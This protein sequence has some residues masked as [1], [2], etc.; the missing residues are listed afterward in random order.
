[1]VTYKQITY[2]IENDLEFKYKTIY[3]DVIQTFFPMVS[4][5]RLKEIEGAAVEVPE[6]MICDKRLREFISK[7]KETKNS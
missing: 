6:C 3:S 2:F 5:P 1:M 7:N 4:E